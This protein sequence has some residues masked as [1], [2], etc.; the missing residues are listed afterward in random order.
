ML[1]YIK[2]VQDEPWKEV[3]TNRLIAT[4]VGF[5]LFF[6]VLIKDK[7]GFIFLIDHANLAF[8]EAGHPIFGL[9]GRTLGLYGGTIGQLV[10]PLIALIAFW[11]KRE[12]I[13]CAVAGVW[14]FENFLNIAIYMAD[15]RKRVL[16]LVGGGEHDWANIFSRWGVLHHTSSI[17][18]FVKTMGWLGMIAI[19][20]W[21][22]WRWYKDR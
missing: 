6:I 22:I 4:S 10:F 7:D 5:F 9:F 20:A 19:W 18:G 17:A 13:A 14:L 1:G 21:V 3:T 12:A 15:A 8:H 16:P 2:E 11:F